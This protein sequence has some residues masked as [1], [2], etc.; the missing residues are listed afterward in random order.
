MLAVNKPPGISTAP[1]HRHEGGAL[2]NRVHGYLG[3]PPKIIHRL[4]HFTS[5]VIVFGKTSAAAGALCR[6]FRERRAEKTYLAIA[7]GGEWGGGA[8]AGGVTVDA[9]IGDYDG[10]K[11]GRAVRG[12]GKAA[13]T[14]VRVVATSAGPQLLDAGA[15]APLIGPGLGE[16]ERARGASA[17]LCYPRTGRTH[18]IRLHLAHLGHPI[19]GDDLYGITGPWIGRQALHAFR[20]KLAHPS[21][22][23]PLEVEAPPPGDMLACAAAL[24][25]D[26]SG[27]HDAR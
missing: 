20:L 1:R 9:P 17:A 11:E 26:L 5:G 12:D 21:S 3:R 14:D 15:P 23:L 25:L 7:Q 6:E 18:Q 19:V 27:V 22:G 4:D 2:W 13:V 10:H 24:G 16:P 8:A